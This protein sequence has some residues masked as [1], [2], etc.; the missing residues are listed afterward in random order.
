MGRDT[1][2]PGDG[3]FV[4][5]DVPYSYTPGPEGVE[6]LEFRHTDYLNIRFAAKTPEAW[7]KIVSKLHERKADWVDEVPPTQ[8]HLVHS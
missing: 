7:E 8:T 3:F 1:L 5:S 6:V 4:G 2:G